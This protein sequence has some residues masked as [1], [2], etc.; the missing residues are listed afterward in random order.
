MSRLPQTKAVQCHGHYKQGRNSVMITE[1]E[2]K[3]QGYYRV[4][5]CQGHYRTQRESAKVTE[6][7]NKCRS[8]YTEVGNVEVTSSRG[9]VGRTKRKIKG[10]E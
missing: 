5:K 2:E 6:G 1:G 4:G 9:G 10:Q 8:P 7:E 3:C